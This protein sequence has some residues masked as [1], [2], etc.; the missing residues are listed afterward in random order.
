MGL[1][2]PRRVGMGTQVA[3]IAGDG[4]RVSVNFEPSHTRCNRRGFA[5]HLLPPSPIILPPPRFPR[6][7]PPP[8]P[9]SMILLPPGG[10]DDAAYQG[11]ALATVRRLDATRHAPSGRPRAGRPRPRR[12]V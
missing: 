3:R 11:L 6:C 5:P 12:P 9:R 1:P 8:R 10:F 2:P 4:W 7:I